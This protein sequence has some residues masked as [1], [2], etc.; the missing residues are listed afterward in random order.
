MMSFAFDPLPHVPRGFEVVPRNPASPPSRMYAYIGGILDAYNKD[1]AVAFLLSAVAK[2]DFREL[3]EAL[4]SFFFQ[5]MGVRLTE[6]QP[7][8]I[9][10]AFVRFGSPVERERFLDQIIQFGHGYTLRFIKHDEGVHVRAHDLDR[11]VWLMLML[12]PNDARNNNAI[13]KAV[14][15]FGLLRYWY[16]STN[17]ARVVCK[18]HLHDEATIP[19][20]VVVA[21][22]IHPRVRTWT[23]PVVV[24]KRKGVEVLGDEDDFPPPNGGLAHPFPP[25]VPRWMGMDGPNPVHAPVSEQH[26]DSSSVHGPEGIE[27]SVVASDPLPAQDLEAPAQDDSPASQDLWFPWKT[28]LRH[29]GKLLV[30]LDTLVPKYINDDDVLLYLASIVFDPLE[31]AERS[32]GF[33]GPLLPVQPLVPYDM[34][35]DEEVMEISAMPASVTPRKRRHHKMKEPLDA[36]FLRRSKRLSKDHGFR[37]DEQAAEASNN[38]S[39]Y[40]AHVVSSAIVAPHLS[41]DAIQGMATG[42]LRMQPEAVS[43]ATLLELDVD[44][45]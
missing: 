25:P 10:D 6:V 33:I 29:I 43:A 44:D 39:I 4:K 5:N 9:R 37:T 3:S 30:S 24:L 23:C 32:P 45:A 2:E 19:D 18:V 1:L 13:A 12:F 17:N 21:A 7:A 38:P 28:Q 8:P 27:Q 11:E 14:A 40:E 22:G 36:S 16:D 31:Q 41:I 26:E 42:Y 34:S 35:D 20:D 15:G